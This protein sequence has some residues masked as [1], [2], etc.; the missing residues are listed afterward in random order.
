MT[1]DT[2]PYSYTSTI[3]LSN[4]LNKMKTNAS[5]ATLWIEQLLLLPVRQTRSIVRDAEFEPRVDV[6]SANP[7]F[8]VRPWVVLDS[9]F[10]EV[11]KQMTECAVCT[12]GL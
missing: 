1:F 4:L 3:L 12:D 5:I 8:L 11:S 6:S 7:Y 2:I 9:V 10:E